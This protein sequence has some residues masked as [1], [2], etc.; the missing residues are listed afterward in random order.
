MTPKFVGPYEVLSRHKTDYEC[1]HVAMGNIEFLHMDRLKPFFGSKQDAWD[2]AM[3]D[4]DQYAVDRIVAHRGNPL[5][6]TEMEFEV[7]FMDGTRLWQTWTKD[8]FDT[9]QYEEYCRA[10]R[11]LHYLVHKAADAK[12]MQKKKAAEPITLVKP[13]DTLYVDLRAYGAE[14]YRQIDLPD[15]DHTLY[16]VEVTCSW[17]S[18]KRQAKKMLAYSAVFN[19]QLVWTNLEVHM[20]GEY[21]EFDASRMTLVDKEFVVSYPHIV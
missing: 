15:R 17:G 14:Y 5:Q 12:E 20:W 4:H 8:L 9:V 3:L 10:R 6:R 21:T 19:E 1:K 2:M 18:G 7:A 13:G 16:V 11:P